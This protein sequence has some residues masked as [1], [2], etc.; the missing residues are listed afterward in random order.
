MRGTWGTRLL[1]SPAHRAM[2]GAQAV[3]GWN[4]RLR[5]GFDAANSFLALWVGKAGGRLIWNSNMGWEDPIEECGM[6]KILAAPFQPL[7]PGMTKRS[8]AQATYQRETAR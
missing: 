7:R 1:W 3:Q 8:A 5:G 2:D 6:K 4:T